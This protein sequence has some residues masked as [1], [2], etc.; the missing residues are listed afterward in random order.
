VILQGV[1]PREDLEYE[2]LAVQREAMQ[3]RIGEINTHPADNQ[4]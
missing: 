4:D 1:Q 3:K 2:A